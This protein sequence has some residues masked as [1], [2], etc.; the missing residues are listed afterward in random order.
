MFDGG[1]VTSRVKV[2]TSSKGSVRVAARGAM[3]LTQRQ[4]LDSGDTISCLTFIVIVRCR[5]RVG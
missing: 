2:D 4:C 1:L 3:A 5:F